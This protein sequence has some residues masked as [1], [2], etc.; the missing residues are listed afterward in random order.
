PDVLQPD[1]AE[2]L[3]PLA[4]GRHAAEEVERLVDAQVEHVGDVPPF[5]AHLERLAVVAPAAADLACDEDIGQE[6]HLDRDQ[7][8]AG[9]PLARRSTTP[10]RAGADGGPAPP[11]DRRGS[12]R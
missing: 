6:M 2:R 12:G 3:Q 10:S 8:V 5:E 1:L 4:D 7:P 9:A 11:P